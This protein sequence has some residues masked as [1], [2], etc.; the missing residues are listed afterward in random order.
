MAEGMMRRTFFCLF[1]T[2]ILA[3]A[4]DAPGISG[5]WHMLGVAESESPVPNHRVDLRFKTSNGVLQGAI[6]NRNNGSEIP[7]A[8][9]EL[10]GATLRFQM[11]APSGQSQAALPIMVMTAN[12]D[13]FEGAWNSVPGPRF[14]LVRAQK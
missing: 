6:I 3:F 13:R 5:D 11:T 9:C 4:V 12:G 10:Q 8:L 1:A 2:A 14:K 7:L